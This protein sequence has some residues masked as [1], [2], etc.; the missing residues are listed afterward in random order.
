MIVV[1]SVGG[2][3]VERASCHAGAGVGEAQQAPRG[4]GAEVALPP[5]RSQN[6][7]GEVRTPSYLLAQA[8]S[9]GSYGLLLGGQT[10]R[11]PCFKDW[12]RLSCEWHRQPCSPELCRVGHLR[13]APLPLVHPR[14]LSTAQTWA[15]LVLL[16]LAKGLLGPR[17]RLRHRPLTDQGQLGFWFLGLWLLSLPWG[18]P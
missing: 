15:G 17:L 3:R 5:T 18:V 12:G 13:R 11:V 14:V 9:P 1:Y 8:T 6:G 4:N 10:P 16:E 7:G 2:T